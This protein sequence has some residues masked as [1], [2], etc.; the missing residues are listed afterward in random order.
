MS[1]LGGLNKSSNGVVIGLVQPQL[2][3]T[4]AP[5]D[6]ERQIEKTVGTVGIAKRGLPTMDLVVA[7]YTGSDGTFDSMDEGMIVNFD[8]SMLA[9]RTTGRADEIIAAEVRPDLVREARV[10]WGVE[11]NIYQF[12]HRG[13]W[14]VLGG[15]HDWSYSYIH[16]LVAGRYRLPWEGAV[17]V[18]D[19][20]PCGFARPTRRYVIPHAEAAE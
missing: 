1:G 8:G 9:H 5:A 11:N 2:P 10:H 6:V 7:G 15:G 13:Y 18:I 17:K 4:A 20:T 19:G 12:V 16:N 14:A 3:V